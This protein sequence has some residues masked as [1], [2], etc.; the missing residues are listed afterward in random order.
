MWASVESSVLQKNSSRYRLLRMEH[1]YNRKQCDI[2][3]LLW[4]S[5]STYTRVDGSVAVQT[6]ILFDPFTYK[7]WHI[8]QIL[9][10]MSHLELE[11][12]DQFYWC[13]LL[14]EQINDLINKSLSKPSQTCQY[15]WEI[16]LYGTDQCPQTCTCT[17][18]CPMSHSFSLRLQALENLTWKDFQTSGTPGSC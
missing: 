7:I 14:I 9:Q 18:F 3:A 6:A 15:L 12:L 10:S 1:E 16:W 13:P 8:C 5:G 2:R 4:V 17:G 11:L